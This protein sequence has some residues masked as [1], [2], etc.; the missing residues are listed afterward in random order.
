[1]MMMLTFISVKS[2]GTHFALMVYFYLHQAPHLPNKLQVRETRVGFTTTL[3][4]HR[5]PIYKDISHWKTK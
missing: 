1:M 5:I 2:H 3:T 4:T